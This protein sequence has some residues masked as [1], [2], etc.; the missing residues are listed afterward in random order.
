M[1]NNENWQS[2]VR[3]HE[4]VL[5]K[6]KHTCRGRKM[7]MN[8]YP[9]HNNCTKK[10]MHVDDSILKNIDC[11]P[12]TKPRLQASSSRQS[13][14]SLLNLHREQY[15]N[16]QLVRNS[17]YTLASMSSFEGML[18]L[19]QNLESRHLPD[20]TQLRWP[21]PDPFSCFSSIYLLSF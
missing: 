16:V 9:A 5:L 2:P 14:Q 18:K 7:I 15:K 20:C 1:H 13:L 3:W 12:R 21:Y 8:L 6:Q 19:A 4:V 11:T 17:F 10:K